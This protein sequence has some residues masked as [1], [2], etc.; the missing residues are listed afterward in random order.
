MRPAPPYSGSQS[1]YWFTVPP[2]IQLLPG[3][4]EGK[5]TTLHTEEQKTTKLGRIIDEVFAPFW[6]DP[7]IYDGLFFI[8]SIALKAITGLRSGLGYTHTCEYFEILLAGWPLS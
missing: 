7:S 4:T 3:R 6:R 8:P 5:A 1:C 2:E